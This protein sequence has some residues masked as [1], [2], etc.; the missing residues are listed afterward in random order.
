MEN[1]EQEMLRWKRSLQ[2]LQIN[3]YFTTCVIRAI[4]VLESFAV[5]QSTVLG[6]LR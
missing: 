5:V 2:K 3:Q 6:M 4:K 1:T